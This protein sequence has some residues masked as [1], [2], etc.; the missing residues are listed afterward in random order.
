MEKSSHQMVALLRL[1]YI[2]DSQMRVGNSKG[3]SG[4]IF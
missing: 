2:I 3:F 1:G 4:D